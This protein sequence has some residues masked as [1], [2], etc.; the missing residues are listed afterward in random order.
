MAINIIR[1]IESSNHAEPSYSIEET[2]LMR[3]K[4]DNLSLEV[5]NEPTFV[6]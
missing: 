2:R 3:A 6:E 1:R 4:E 5:R